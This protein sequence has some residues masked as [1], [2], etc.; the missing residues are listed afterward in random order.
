[1]PETY[2]LK[3]E[4]ESQAHKMANTKAESRKTTGLNYARGKQGNRCKTFSGP[5]EDRLPSLNVGFSDAHL[6]IT[7]IQVYVHTHTHTSNRVTTNTHC[8][9]HLKLR[10]L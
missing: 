8:N 1:M 4:L 10:K 6:K 3:D 2:L 5:E 7:Y 9:V